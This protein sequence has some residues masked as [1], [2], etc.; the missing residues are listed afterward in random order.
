[1]SSAKQPRKGWPNLCNLLEVQALPYD[2]AS[3]TLTG[4]ASLRIFRTWPKAITNNPKKYNKLNWNF[5]KIS[6]VVSRQLPPSLHNLS[7]SVESRNVAHPVTRERKK[8]S[9][10]NLRTKNWGYKWELAWLEFKP[11]VSLLDEQDHFCRGRFD[12]DALINSNRDLF[13]CKFLGCEFLGL[14]KFGCYNNM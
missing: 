6:V 11:P 9:M 8:E 4:L 7:D 10:R 1:M 2:T 5:D 14:F 3:P 12:S 13:T